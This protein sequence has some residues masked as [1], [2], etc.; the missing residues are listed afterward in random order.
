MHSLYLKPCIRNL[1]A[2]ITNMKICYINKLSVSLDS[3]VDHYKKNSIYPRI[4]THGSVSIGKFS[5]T[6]G[7]LPTDLYL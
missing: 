6:H 1:Y 3:V 7:L 5:I 2:N 4:I